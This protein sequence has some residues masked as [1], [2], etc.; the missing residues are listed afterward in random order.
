MAFWTWA[1]IVSLKLNFIFGIELTFELYDNAKDCFYEVIEKNTS[2]TL[3]YQVKKLVVS[4]ICQRVAGN[5][6]Q[7]SV[8]RLLLV[9]STMSTSFWKDP[10]VIRYISNTNLNS[11]V[12]HS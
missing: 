6:L 5:Y 1:L 10:T 2:V 3:E 4:F 11:I 8:L 9:D 12:T 7:N